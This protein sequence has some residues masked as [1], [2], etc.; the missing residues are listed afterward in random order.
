[1]LSLFP[2][3]SAA[4]QIVNDIMGALIHFSLRFRIYLWVLPV[5][6]VSHKLWAYLSILLICK[7]YYYHNR[8]SFVTNIRPTID[9]NVI[10]ITCGLQ[11]PYKQYSQIHSFV[12]KNTFAFHLMLSPIF[13]N[14]NVAS[15]LVI[16]QLDFCVCFFRF[17]IFKFLYNRI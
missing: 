3:F 8:S 2:V 5:S 9:D 16:I 13:N 7:Y 10:T 1:M 15:N 4:F 17:Q 11:V 14:L 12:H 6:F